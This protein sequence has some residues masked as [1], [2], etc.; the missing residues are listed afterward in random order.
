MAQQKKKPINYVSLIIVA[1]LI[2]AGAGAIVFYDPGTPTP[3]VKFDDTYDDSW[4]KLEKPDAQATVT[5]I[6]ISWAG[7]SDR[8]KPKDPKRTQEQ[9][10]KLVEELWHK[11]RNNPSDE[12]WKALQKEHNE[13][14]APHTEYT[15]KT[16][17]SGLDEK[18]NSLGLQTKAK[19]AR[20]VES[21]FGYHL[22]R[23]ER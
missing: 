15:C 9:A 13:D 7:K 1:A 4:G 6:L 19:H 8:S 3:H 18:F 22:I 16:A 2:G 21:S 11:Y 10:K 14:T 23:R 5:H 12:N 20:Y 17:G